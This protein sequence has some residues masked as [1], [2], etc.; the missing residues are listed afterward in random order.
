MIKELKILIASILIAI[1]SCSNK[2]EVLKGDVQFSGSCCEGGIVLYDNSSFKI[3]Y[4]T[5]NKS[6]TLN[7]DYYIKGNKIFLESKELPNPNGGIIVKEVGDLFTNQYQFKNNKL[8]PDDLGNNINITSLDQKYFRL[9]CGF[10]QTQKQ[11]TF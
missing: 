4:S 1:S 2:T 8:V 3:S 6:G 5:N 9:P 10:E 11:G 7:G